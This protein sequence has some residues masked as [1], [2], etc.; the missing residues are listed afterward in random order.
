MIQHEAGVGRRQAVDDQGQEILLS[1]ASLLGKL[2]WVGEKS[3]STVLAV[4]LR[5]KSHLANAKSSLPI[6]PFPRG[7]PSRRYLYIPCIPNATAVGPNHRRV[8][9][10]SGAL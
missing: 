6:L 10:G 2:S 7:I 5:G 9:T 8:P 1:L 3:G 4:S